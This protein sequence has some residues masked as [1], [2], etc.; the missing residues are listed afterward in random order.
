MAK[1]KNLTMTESG[2]YEDL[3]NLRFEF[4]E[5]HE[6]ILQ[7][8]LVTAADN[9]DKNKIQVTVTEKNKYREAIKGCR[10]NGIRLESVKVNDW[11][12]EYVAVIRPKILLRQVNKFRKAAGEHSPAA[13]IKLYVER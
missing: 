7:R 10:L 2:F 4:P 1:N 8:M 3:H 6:R 11:A 9:L 5:R 12:Y 13:S